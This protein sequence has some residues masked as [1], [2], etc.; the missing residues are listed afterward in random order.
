MLVSPIVLDASMTA[1]EVLTRLAKNGLWLDPSEPQASAWISES[2]ALLD[3]SPQ[4][5]ARQLARPVAGA[6]AAIRRQW[7][8]NVLWYIRPIGFVLDRC[9]SVPPE[10][11]LLDALNLHEPDSRLP[12]ALPQPG[13]MPAG[14]GLVLAGDT[15]VA[16][17]M[18]L[19]HAAPP[20]PPRREESSPTISPGPPPRP[21]PVPGGA[22]IGTTTGTVERYMAPPP[23]AGVDLGETRG[24][25]PAPST[26][27]PERVVQ[28]WPRL[29]A[30]E[31]VPARKKFS[32]VV[33]FARERQREVSGGPVTLRAPQGQDQVQLTVELTAHG[34]EAPEGWTRPMPTSLADP[35]SASVTFLLIG[36][37]PPGPEP[38]HLT[39]LEIRYLMENG[40]VC[41][42]ASKPLV[43]GEAGQTA[44]NVRNEG[45]PWLAQPPTGSAVDLTP[46]VDPPDLTIELMKPDGNA[47]RGNYVC[48]LRSPH[49]IKAG[50][51]PF[52]IDFGED[53]KSFARTIVDRIR[54]YGATA[55]VDN[56]LR[57]F[58]GAVSD[59]LPQA[60]HDALREVAAITAPRPPAVLFISAEPYV[61]W[62]LAHIDPPLDPTRPPYLGAQVL[63]GRWLRDK[64]ID[65][66]PGATAP[67]P[68]EPVRIE[69]PPVAP[70]RE[71]PVRHMAVV[72]GIYPATSGFRSLP[73]AKVEATDLTAIYQAIPLAASAQSISQLLDAKLEQNFVPVGGADA[74]HFAGHGE[75]DPN[76]PDASVLFLSDGMPLSSD[77]FRGAR[78]GGAQQPLIFL[79]AC[80]I[81]IGG[82]MLGDMG[83]FPGNCLKGGFGGVLG[84]LWE[85]ND[86]LARNIAMEFWKRVMPPGG[87]PGE[88]IA[89][90]LRD[91]RAAYALAAPFVPTYLAYVYYGHPRLRLHRIP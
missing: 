61:P 2:V 22:G 78:Y 50:R 64:P 83:G 73:E 24:G 51:G 13:R 66:A 90:V 53:A 79:N 33:G 34:V 54:L 7:F 86:L 39:R 56:Y 3:I 77:L 38:V 37:D 44:L 65:D 70:P 16:V 11:T 58:G 25:S 91:I 10:V 48:R 62:E 21:A 63:L 14:E 80:M 84:A 18:S 82:E 15:P 12:I 4:D 68:G 69:K 35:A 9:Q 27:P 28:T 32:V 8:A 31:Y 29:D 42:T 36:I 81:G 26:A 49:K 30:P 72:A 43:I 87:G 45:T 67:L 1:A 85:V 5:A 55:L 75:F 89:E 23:W 19:P 52:P 17:S 47:A 20:P 46:D 71:I 59:K 74:V 6:M 76:R 60:A 41:G 57:A 40:E 88:P